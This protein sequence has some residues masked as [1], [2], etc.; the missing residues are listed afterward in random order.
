[1]IDSNLIEQV[2][3]SNDIVDIIST[4][5]PLKKSGSNYKGLCPFHE[6]R[7]PSLMVSE[8]KQIFK[9]F[10][11]GKAGNVITFV[12]EMEK[13]SYIEAVKKLA[14]RVG[15]TIPD[16]YKKNPQETIRTKIIK[17]YEESKNYYVDN[18]VKFGKSEID[19]LVNRGIS[20]EL[21]SKFNI[22]L[23]LN[24]YTGLLNH[25]Q[26]HK[27]DNEILISSGLVKE[28]KRGLFDYIR[29]RIM[30]PIH[31]ISGQIVAYG[32]RK[33]Q[34]EKG[35]PKYI[36]SP[37]T[38]IY[39][40]GNELYG[41]FLSK[42]E[43]NKHN[44][45]M[46]C[47]GYIDFLRLYSEGFTNSVASLG[48]ALTVKQ[49]KLLSRYSRNILLMYDGDNAGRK[50][51]VQN[52][53]LCIE[54][55][56]RPKVVPFPDGEDPDSYILKFGKDSFQELVNKAI[57][58]LTYV[59]NSSIL[60]DNNTDKVKYLSS[61]ASK[62]VDDIEREMFIKE[63]SDEFGISKRTLES[64]VSTSVLSQRVRSKKSEVDLMNYKE[65]KELLRYMINYPEEIK[66][67]C[68]EINSDYIMNNLNKRLYNILE[69]L[70][71]EI[72]S[73]SQIVS[74]IQDE[75]VVSYVVE[76]SMTNIPFD[77]PGNII[78]E[79]KLRKLQKDL[80]SVN[81]KINNSGF[82]RELLLEKKQIKNEIL[83]L[84]QSVVSNILS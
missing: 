77:N 8:T 57:P 83:Q 49:I 6:D 82:S 1:M 44:S 36:N 15:I 69:D 56:L 52:G 66:I 26:R 3:Q 54:Q 20:K 71:D 30:F 14:Q 81:Q 4:Y 79:V 11:C 63:I 22:G 50:A 43:I 34:V 19:Y 21:V 16:S 40:K 35:E 70:Q 62:I 13:I 48:T 55:G 84:N 76:L 42:Y 45:A 59:K 61:S 67:I 46:I 29:D 41:L 12:M 38:D 2:R 51:N 25:L 17:V 64:K 27:F 78:K 80:Q 10:V 18:L 33:V 65:E 32:G 23:S 5:I 7:N 58:Y 74:L 24:S 68:E 47:E 60:A 75:A 9:C 73:E 28:G 39:T 37:T 53:L 72:V 31:S